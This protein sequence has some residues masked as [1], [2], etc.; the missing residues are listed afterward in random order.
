MVNI[1]GYDVEVNEPTDAQWE[2]GIIAQVLIMVPKA[3]P[4]ELNIV[5]KDE[6]LAI[7]YLGNP[8]ESEIKDN[9][10]DVL[11]DYM[12]TIVEVIE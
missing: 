5:E 7:D 3:F 10:A 1:N 12:Y 4:I 8:Y 11:L 9:V 6:K 2:A